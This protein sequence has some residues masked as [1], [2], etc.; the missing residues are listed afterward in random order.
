MKY[1][2]SFIIAAVCISCASAPKMTVS[3]AD[4]NKTI[5]LKKGDIFELRL[6]AQPSTGYSWQVTSIKNAEKAGE[7][8]IITPEETLPGGVETQIMR[9]KALAPGEG[10]IILQ[11]F[12]PWEKKSESD[13]K[14]TVRLNV[15]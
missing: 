14:F 7:D 8:K 3:D 6:K 1:F 15:E 11:Y 9:F 10:E 12:R 13:K 4:D 5:S 2:F